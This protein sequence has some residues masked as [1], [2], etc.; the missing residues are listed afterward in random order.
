MRFD[1]VD[2]MLVRLIVQD[3]GAE[4]AHLPARNAE[5]PEHDVHGRGKVLAEPLLGVE[6]EVVQLPHPRRCR[7][8]FQRVGE[9]PLLDEPG[10][11]RLRLVVGGCGP[12]GAHDR[13]GE[14][15]DL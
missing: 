3:P 10:F 14:L 1:G 7:G 9:S 5:H 8:G 6:E 13:L 11:D 2:Q 4:A 12:G 15:A